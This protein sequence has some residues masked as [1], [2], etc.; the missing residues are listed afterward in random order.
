MQTKIIVILIP[1]NDGK[2]LPLGHLF[3]MYRWLL[4]LSPLLQQLPQFWII[5]NPFQLL[6]HNLNHILFYLL[7][8]LLDFR[9]H[10][11]VTLSIREVHNFRYLLVHLRLR[12]N[13]RIVHH[14]FGMENLL[15]DALVKVVG[16]RADKH[17]LREVTDFTGRNKAV[18]LCADTG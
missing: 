10:G 18:Q 14:Y 11:I 16:H 17:P 8:V 9:L 2:E 13:R 5:L 4:S 7:V 1:D 12:C 3:L 15:V 6:L